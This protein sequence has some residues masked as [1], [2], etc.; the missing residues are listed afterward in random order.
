MVLL[1]SD[2]NENLGVYIIIVEKKH[3]L[4][5]DYTRDQQHI[6]NQLYIFCSSNKPYFNYDREKPRKYQRDVVSR[7]RNDYDSY[8]KRLS[9]NKPDN[10]D[11]EKDCNEYCS[12][13]RP[14]QAQPLPNLHFQ[15][16]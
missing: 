4:F 9:N 1:S 7:H 14:E 16:N 10:K 5:Y 8:M 12:E 13:R 2:K 6:R 3:S 11:R 15:Y